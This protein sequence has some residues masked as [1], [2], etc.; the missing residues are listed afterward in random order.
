MIDFVQ[1]KKAS[2]GQPQDLQTHANASAR[3]HQ[4]AMQ[5]KV[6][7]PRTDLRQ[8]SRRQL[9]DHAEA[10]DLGN[11]IQ[12]ASLAGNPDQTKT[13]RP[14]AREADAM[15][16]QSGVDRY[17]TSFEGFDDSTVHSARLEH[18]LQAQARGQS[19]PIS[20]ATYASSNGDTAS[21][22]EGD[23][24][25]YSKERNQVVEHAHHE[26]FSQSAVNDPKGLSNTL[27]TAYGAINSINNLI[28]HTIAVSSYPTTTNGDAIELDHEG[29]RALSEEYYDESDGE[30]D[31][32]EP[33]SP[34]AKQESTVSTP[35]VPQGRGATMLGHSEAQ[36]PM[37]LLQ[38]HQMLRNNT[39][40]DSNLVSRI[41]GS[42]ETFNRQRAPLETSMAKNSAGFASHLN[43]PT[44]PD[45]SPQRPFAP[46]QNSGLISV[47][48]QERPTSH[49]LKVED[50]ADREEPARVFRPADEDNEVQEPLDE[51]VLDYDRTELY[52][53]PFKVLQGESFDVD[54][55]RPPE[56]LPEE[57]ASAD[58]CTRLSFTY[59]H[60]QL[61][62]KAAFFNSLSID[63]W[64][65]AGDWFVNRFGELMKKMR[66]ARKEKRKLASEF[67]DEVTKRNDQVERKR[68]R[69]D[70]VTS[71][72]KSEGV[73][74][75]R[76]VTPQK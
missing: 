13:R 44:K 15:S 35:P 19:R 3:R 34:A 62:E 17:D 66:G 40:S 4:A 57:R 53:K 39:N 45:G 60:L 69:L 72:M 52:D 46:V 21:F 27:T 67:E 33:S 75:L 59:E 64:E 51:S 73:G 18:D 41:T 55:R 76:A 29:N 42:N 6:D 24:G 70:E 38:R 65:E 25:A 2:R 8:Q 54:P 10:R 48:D 56:V 9:S 68:I 49:G 11:R 63:E 47:A 23:E 1:H 28:S 30:D 61:P 71:R 22:Y 32:E 43:K 14:I 58:L 74:L 20:R 37:H 7:V 31:D 36:A 5:A 50:D 26:Q 16:L 12:R